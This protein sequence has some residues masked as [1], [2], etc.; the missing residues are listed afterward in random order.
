MVTTVTM[1]NNEFGM[2]ST[3]STITE[4]FDDCD[5]LGDDSEDDSFESALCEMYNDVLFYAIIP[6]EEEEIYFSCVKMK[7]KDEDHNLCTNGKRERFLTANRD[8]Y[9]SLRSAAPS[10]GS[11]FMLSVSEVQSCEDDDLSYMTEND[12]D[13]RKVL[14][15]YEGFDGENIQLECMRCPWVEE[16]TFEEQEVQV[17]GLE[18]NLIEK[19]TMPE[20]DALLEGEENYSSNNK[21]HRNTTYSRNTRGGKDDFDVSCV[22]G[23]G[24]VRSTTAATLE[25]TESSSR[26][27]SFGSISLE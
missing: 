8:S 2:S 26:N 21:H 5:Q 23:F 3:N 18:A 17:K 24:M 25:S 4:Y 20:F 16:D 15:K 19:T 1:P 9:I 10:M 14:V 13:E 22:L 7:G 6:E 11:S 12:M 27:D